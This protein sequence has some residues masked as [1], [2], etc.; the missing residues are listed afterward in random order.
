MKKKEESRKT[1]IETVTAHKK[2]RVGSDAIKQRR[3]LYKKAVRKHLDHGSD[4]DQLLTR[5]IRPKVRR[6]PKQ[7][8][9]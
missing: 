2:V 7:G 8:R 9:R 5:R 6:Q 3:K 4:V 1:Q